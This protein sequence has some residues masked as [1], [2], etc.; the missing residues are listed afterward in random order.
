MEPLLQILFFEIFLLFFISSTSISASRTHSIN[1]VQH[2]LI[3]LHVGVP[4]W[5]HRYRFYML[6]VMVLSWD[7]E[8]NK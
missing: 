8:Q 1:F 2:P 7:K 6:W 4:F 3:I 5:Q